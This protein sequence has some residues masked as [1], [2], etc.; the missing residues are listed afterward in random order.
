MLRLT[1]RRYLKQV[2]NRH[3]IPAANPI[4][5]TAKPAY[6]HDI[7][8]DVPVIDFGQMCLEPVKRQEHSGVG[9]NASIVQQ[10]RPIEKNVIGIIN[11]YAFPACHG[12]FCRPGHKYNFVQRGL[13]ERLKDGEES[14]PVKVWIQ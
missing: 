3:F 5:I 2:I 12:L 11:E 6:N 14:S 1:T 9:R 10:W 7:A 4:L 8:L 13:I